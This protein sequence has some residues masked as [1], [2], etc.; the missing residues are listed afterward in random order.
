MAK[1]VMS[2][3]QDVRE[4]APWTGVT[5]TM[6]WDPTGSNSRRVGLATVR[7]GGIVPLDADAAPNGR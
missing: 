2:E 7:Q 6:A 5:G 1:V 3:E 4:L